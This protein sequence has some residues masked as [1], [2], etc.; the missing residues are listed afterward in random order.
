MVPEPMDFD[1]AEFANTC[2]EM[3]DGELQTV[4][5]VCDN[6]VMKHVIDKFSEDIKTEVISDKKFKATL[7]VAASKTF[8]AWCFR[9]AGQMQITGPEKVVKEYK[10]M[11][12][13]VIEY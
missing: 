9:F 4:E 13:K 1:M 8:Y 5:I 12:R 7:N 3:F 6:E 10:A 2:N 11:A